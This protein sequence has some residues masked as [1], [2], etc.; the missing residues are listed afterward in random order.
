MERHPL[1]PIALV[2]GLATV[3]GGVVALLQQTGVITLGPTVVATLVCLVG[4][5]GGAILVLLSGRRERPSDGSL[6]VESR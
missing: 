1:D 2:V 6:D 5:L 4:A 3:L